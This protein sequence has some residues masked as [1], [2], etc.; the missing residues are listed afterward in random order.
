MEP[1]HC[2]TILAL[3]VFVCGTAVASAPVE[4]ACVGDS[5][6]FGVHSTGGNH[7]YPGQLQILF[8]KVQ[9]MGKYK[10]TNLGNSGKMMLKNSSAPY[11]KTSQFQ[12]L[13]SKEWDVVILMLGTNDAHNTC[14]APSSR[15]GCSSNWD[16]DCGGPN[17]TSLTNCQFA[18]DFTSMVKLL[19]GTTPAGPK[20]YVMIPPPLMASNPGFPTM[21][22][23]INTLFPKL[24]PLMQ[25]STPGVVGLIDIYGG[26]GG[27]PNWQTQFPP[28]CTLN[29]SWPFCPLWC[30]S[31]SCDQC[32]PDDNGYAFFA[33]LVYTGLGFAA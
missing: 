5:I 17:H 4:V 26:M 30:D 3:L 23:T 33:K 19:K 24:I 7:T 22:I 10:V 15:P 28:A 14:N 16:T 9:G 20:V 2:H 18:E 11:W 8:D 25:K 6:T 29:S 31:Q 12:T 13:I 1:N 32:H 27:S 21:Q